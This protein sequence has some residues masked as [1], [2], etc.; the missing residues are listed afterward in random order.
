MRSRWTPGF[1]PEHEPDH[2]ASGLALL[3]WLAGAEADALEDDAPALERVRSLTVRAEHALGWMPLHRAVVVRLGSPLYEEALALVEALLPSAPC[4]AIPAFDPPTRPARR[5][6]IPAA[7]GM[8]WTYT[9]LT[10]IARPLGLPAGM[11]SRFEILDNLFDESARFAVRTEL[12]VALDAEL[13]A[14][15][16]LLPPSVEPFRQAIAKTRAF[17]RE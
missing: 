13:V 5:L 14:F 7:T 1:E 6:A 9:A 2:L 4:R 15:D 10:R 16:A 11:R 8:V 17:L 3:A 12:V